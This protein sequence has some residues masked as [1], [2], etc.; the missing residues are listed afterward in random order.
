LA[1]RVSAQVSIPGAL[2]VITLPLGYEPSPGD[3]VVFGC[4]TP[5]RCAS[6]CAPRRAKAGDPAR[7]CPQLAAAASRTGGRAVVRVGYRPL[8]PRNSTTRHS[9]SETLPGHCRRPR[10]A[11][12]AEKGTLPLSRPRRAH[13][14]ARHLTS[15]PDWKDP[16]C[17]LL[18]SPQ[19]LML[20]RLL[21]AGPKVFNGRARRT[22]EKLTELGLVKSYWES[23]PHAKGGG[24]YM[25]ESITVV[26]NWRKLDS[27]VARLCEQIEAEGWAVEF[28]RWCEDAETPGILGQRSGCTIDSSSK[29]KIK[30]QG[31]GR[32]QITATLEHEL[33]HLHGATHATDY[34]ELGLY[35]GGG[36]NAYGEAVSRP[37][38]PQIAAAPG[39]PVELEL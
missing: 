35:C 34:P 9:G 22:I 17:T 37:R 1:D 21:T 4:L 11:T 29:I 16:R 36:A 2:S 5:T 13:F 12:E 7:S 38:R 26:P 27:R 6:R 33:E 8:S 24:M 31:A 39:R 20:G 30:T 25:S 19:E 32:E 14:C 23:V 28:P 15:H 18:T 10:I 3:L